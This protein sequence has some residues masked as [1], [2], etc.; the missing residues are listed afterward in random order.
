[1]SIDQFFNRTYNRNTYNCA[2]FVVEVIHRLKGVDISETMRG[3]LMP[4]KERT[5]RASLRRA[6]VKLEKPENYCIVLMQ[7]ARTTP[8]VGVYIDGRVLQIHERGVEY[9]DLDLASRGFTKTG[10]YQCLNK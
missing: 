5:V 3:F 6:F 2:H 4:P 9:V 1:M 7:R 10:F 8:H